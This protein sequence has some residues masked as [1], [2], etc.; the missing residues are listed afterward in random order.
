MNRREITLFGTALCVAGVLAGS[1]PASAQVTFQSFRCV[2]GSQ[3]MVAFYKYDKRAHVHIDGKSLALG[4]RLGLS[5]ANYSGGGF[6]LKITK[7]GAVLRHAK[8]QVTACE[9]A[10]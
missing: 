3:F 10:T 6:R 2:D 1:S 5:G 8:G 7:T 4:K 9:P